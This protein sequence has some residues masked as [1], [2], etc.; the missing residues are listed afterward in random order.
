MWVVVWQ[1]EVEADFLAFYHIFDILDDPKLDGPRLLRLAAQ[2][3]RYQ[4]AVRN[5]LEYEASLD[6]K[7][8][9]VRE[10]D[11]TFAPGE[12]MSMSEALARSKGDDMAVL[13]SLSNDSRNAGLGDLFE[14]ETG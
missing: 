14:Y 10:G 6:Q 3:P 2:L 4:G 7:A 5:R 11:P 13:N 9:E 1:E 8:V 12:T